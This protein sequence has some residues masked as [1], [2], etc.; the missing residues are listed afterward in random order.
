MILRTPDYYGKFRCI[1]SRCLHNCCIGWGID[2]DDSSYAR[3]IRAGGS[4]GE[5]LRSS[6]IEE[7]GFHTFTMDGERC[8]F[9][10]SN[11]LCDIFINLGENALCSVCTEYPRFEE[12]FGS[13]I[14]KGLGMS[15]EEAARIIL[16]RKEP[17]VLTES[18]IGGIIEE[19]DKVMLGALLRSRTKLINLL[20]DR[21]VTV[22]TRIFRAL[23]YADT[24]QKS[25]N[26]NTPEA[27]TDIFM[28]PDAMPHS[29]AAITTFLDMFSELE[30]LNAEWDDALS[31]LKTAFASEAERAAALETLSV[32]RR[33]YVYEQTSV[34]FI[35]R[36]YLKSMYDNDARAKVRFMALCHIITRE[37]DAAV[38]HRNGSLSTED[39]IENR[40]IF[41]SQNEH[42]ADALDSIADE[43][44]FTNGLEAML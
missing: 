12:R 17:T 43:L 28:P 32:S 11:N 42:S 18:E 29:P 10:N 23:S 8:S 2:I 14:E 26:N 30:S 35:Y 37:L 22:E 7:D 38:L 31:L 9:L 15:C 19:T 25:I 27:I 5:R 6:I 44:L 39:Q 20:Q 41:C 3:Y 13:L 33:E 36:Y 4:F 24:V 34:Y 16:S 40:R 1:G 21:T